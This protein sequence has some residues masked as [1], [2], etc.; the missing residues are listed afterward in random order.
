VCT[1][2]FT[3]CSFLNST[4]V[5]F[6]EKDRQSFCQSAQP[7]RLLTSF[8]QIIGSARRA[9]SEKKCALAKRTRGGAYIHHHAGSSVGSG[10]AGNVFQGSPTTTKWALALHDTSDALVERNIAVDFPGA[11]IV[12]WCLLNP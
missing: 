12:L 5:D 3:V 2:Y 9:P 4:A 8:I 7:N 6:P 10:D 1:T 11:G